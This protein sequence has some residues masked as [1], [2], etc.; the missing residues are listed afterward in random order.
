VSRSF[1]K[2]GTKTAL[3]V[4]PKPALFLLRNSSSIMPRKQG[5]LFKWLA[6]FAE[7][8]GKAATAYARRK[9]CFMVESETKQRVFTKITS[10]IREKLNDW[11]LA[12]PHVIQSP[13]TN[14]T[15]LIGN[16]N[17]GVTT[18]VPKLLLEISIRELHK[19]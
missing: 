5:Q 13:I 16:R 7:W 8:N 1:S 12:H 9:Q 2:G 17:T 15:L 3:F 18:C 10:E 14:D 4:P 19:D 6:L 11:I